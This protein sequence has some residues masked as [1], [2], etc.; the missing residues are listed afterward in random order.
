MKKLV[1]ASVCGA[2]GLGALT[3][4]APSTASACGGFFCDGG[5]S[6]MPV[7]QTGEDIIFVMTDSQVEAHIRIEYEGEAENFAWVI[8]VQS[9]PTFAVSSEAFVEAVKTASVP[10]YGT[11]VNADDCQAPGLTG[12]GFGSSGAG[13]TGS[14]PDDNEGGSDTDDGGV[15]VKVEETVGAYDIKVITGESA[16]AVFDWLGENGYQQDMAALPLIEQYLEENHYFVAVKL[17]GG[18]EVEELHPIALTF[19][20][21]EACVPL[22]LTAIA[23][24]DDMAVRTYF[25]ADSRVVPQNY[26]HVLVNPLKIDWT[27]QALNYV[28]VVTRAVDAENADGRAFVT[29]YAGDSSGVDT[30]A[31]FSP[32]WDSSVFEGS[33]PATALDLLTAQNLFRC[34]Y[35]WMT[36]MDICRGMHPMVDPLLLEF[37]V[38][39]GVEPNDFYLNPEQYNDQID[40]DQWGNGVE[41]GELLE[42]RVIEPGR[43]AADVVRAS[44]Y[45]TRMFTT[46]SPHEMTVD[47]I[48]HKNPDLEDVDNVRT[49][50][51][52]ILCNGDSVWTL[53]DGREVYVPA[54]DP[55]PNIGGD[56]FWEEEVDEIAEFGAPMVLVSN[57]NAINSALTDYNRSFNWEGSMGNGGAEGGEAAEGE[58]G[59]GGCGCQVDSST[60]ALW[61]VFFTFGLG[62]VATRRRRRR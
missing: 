16:D 45:L 42:Q 3:L 49:G 4:L 35:D 41:F 14:A 54:G 38:P 37:V 31:F 50:T 27:T 53:P 17:N 43:H 36:D 58:G 8:P 40:L 32:N 46:I 62:M 34:D 30:S 61:S 47:P 23:A 51:R 44:P 10:T 9:V 19:D 7:D 57:T 39:E 29:E 12:D 20:N 21:V 11:T 28:D 48:F 59:A 52:R 56:E 6:P 24:S 13:A 2:L 15:S 33:T 55:W 60:G 26:R 5:P 22:R 18:A 25:L 1:L